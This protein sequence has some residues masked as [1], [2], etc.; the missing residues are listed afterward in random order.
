MMNVQDVLGQI[1]GMECTR[2]E[3]PTGS[4]LS[5]DFG[6]LSRAQDDPPDSRSHG[7]RHLTVLSPWRLHEQNHVRCDW[8]SDD[9]SSAVRML[10]GRTVTAAVTN[11]PGWDIMM[12]LSQ[13]FALYVF[14]DQ[15][16]DYAWFMLGSDGLRLTVSP[17]TAAEPG[18]HLRL[19]ERVNP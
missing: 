17:S 19:P 10:A 7:E 8:N 15:S 18:W 5:L 2:A 9:I 3:N 13:G 12:Q 14:G 1:V 6:K 4:I 16:D 11:S